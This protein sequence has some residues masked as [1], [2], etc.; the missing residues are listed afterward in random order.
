M[1]TSKKSAKLSDE[2]LEA[3]EKRRAELL[4]RIRT[5]DPA[6]IRGLTLRTGAP[7]AEEVAGENFHEYWFASGGGFAEVFIEYAAMAELEANGAE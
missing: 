1:A 4:E 2:Q 5:I 6:S 7:P 3:M